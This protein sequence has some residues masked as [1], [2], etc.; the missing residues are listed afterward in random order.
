MHIFDFT[1]RLF[2]LLW[3]V[4]CA[5]CSLIESRRSSDIVAECEGKTLTRME[6]NELTRGLN[7]EDSLA[8]AQAYIRQWAVDWLEYGAAQD[9]PSKEIERLVEDYRHSL[10]IHQYEQRLVAQRMPT[11]IADSTIASFY[12]TH[13]QHFILRESIVRGILL[14]VPNGAPKMDELRKALQ[15]PEQEE[16]LE[17][18]EKYAYQYATGYELFLDAWKTTNQILL[19]MP[20]GKDDIR[21]KLKSNKQIELQD[22]VN[23]YL[24][25]VTDIRAIGDIMPLDF[26]TPEIEKILLSKRQVEFLQ[27]ERNDLYEQA[28]HDKRLKCYNP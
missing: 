8:V 16:N 26:A 7:A 23:T 14:V 6:L 19:R 3:I 11:A 20:S 18:I 4:A 28:L 12:E 17:S 13:R 27:Q 22:T 15:A 25:Q 21:N 1:K 24:L 10:Y 5:G 9:M 2:L